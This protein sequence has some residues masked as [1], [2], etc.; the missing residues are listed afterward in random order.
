MNYG[1]SAISDLFIFPGNA[2]K[3]PRWEINNIEDPRLRGVR[4]CARR[5]SPP[6]RRSAVTEKLPCVGLGPLFGCQLPFVA[7]RG[8]D[9]A[10][11]IPT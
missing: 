7:L 2:L 8:C 5:A 1:G 9:G 3:M 6:S 4:A 11:G 10:G